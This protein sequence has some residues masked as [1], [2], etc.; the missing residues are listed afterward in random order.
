MFFSIC[1]GHFFLQKLF[2]KLLWQR[3]RFFFFAEKCNFCKVLES[4]MDWVKLV[5]FLIP[6]LLFFFPLKMS[7]WVMVKFL[8]GKKNTQI[9][10]GK[11]NVKLR[12]KKS[13]FNF[14]WHFLEFFVQT[15]VSSLHTFSGKKKKCFFSRNQGKKILSHIEFGRDMQTFP[16]K[17]KR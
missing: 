4:S 13:F 7:E 10:Q 3:Y 6:G 1:I 2:R 14:F 9:L 15:R 5:V 8:L 12:I 11:N 16:E 17:K